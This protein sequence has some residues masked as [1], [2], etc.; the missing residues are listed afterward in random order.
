[1]NDIA[2]L[3]IPKLPS[4]LHMTTFTADSARIRLDIELPAP[5]RLDS[6]EKAGPRAKIWFDPAH[7]TV[8]LL[9]AGGLCPGMNDVVRSV[10]LE[11]RHRY[12]VERVL[13]FRYGFEGLDPHAAAPPVVLTLDQVRDIH[14]RGGTLLG[15]SRGAHDPE[16]LVESLARQRVDV[17]F[18]IGGDG[19]MRAAHGLHLAARKAGLALGVVGIPKTIDNDVP[20]VDK[21]FGFDTAVATAR[22]VIEAAHA[23]ARS[24]RNGVGLVKLM[25]RNAGFIAA[26]ATLASRD[27]NACLIPEVG[28]ELERLYGW[29]ER[30]L[31][32]R[33]HAVVVIAEGCAE[34][35]AS[36]QGQSVDSSGNRRFSTRESD[37]GR[38]LAS[39]IEAHFG[40]I[41]TPLTLKLLDPSY[42][43][44]GL[45]ASS[46]DAMYCDALARNAVH[47]A[48]AGKTDMLVGRW[49]RAFTHVPLANV[50][51]T[52]K[53]VDP[54][55]EV[56]RQVLES[57]G[58]PPL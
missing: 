29:L 7:T 30:R 14:L 27:V 21:T 55:G 42:L 47:A 50:I 39:R 15:T 49:H 26:H 46:E 31:S 4:P 51:A 57:T 54:E 58:Q 16:R 28:F 38:S 24:V 23:E 10:V 35:L 5:E 41:P 3:G 32:E 19:T 53:T 18:A 43:L 20:F 36:T 44:R 2:T 34:R 9:T 13:G 12:G 25:G 48:M 56:W 1:M 52:T 33:G 45:R 17:L 37:V 40:A 6:F 8:G 11:L 22:L